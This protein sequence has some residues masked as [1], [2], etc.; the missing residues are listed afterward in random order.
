M[1]T[2]HVQRPNPAANGRKSRALQNEAHDYYRRRLLMLRKSGLQQARRGVQFQPPD[3]YNATD[4]DDD[5]DAD[6]DQALRKR[7]Q[8][9]DLDTQRLLDSS[10]HGIESES[11]ND[12]ATPLVDEDY[13][14]K[15]GMILGRCVE[16]WD[17][18]SQILDEGV[19]RNPEVDENFMHTAFENQLYKKFLLFIEVAPAMIKTLR[20]GNLNDAGS[21]L[22]ARLDRVIDLGRQQARRADANGVRSA[23]GQWPSINWEPAFPVVR[24]LL[25]FNHNTSGQL[26]CPVTLDWDDAK[27]REGLRRGTQDLT[28]ADLPTF[29]WPD[30]AFYT[31]DAYNGFLRS[32]LLVTTYKHIFISPSSA[33][34]TN[35]ST[36]GG[37]AA[38]H[39]ITFVTYESIAYVATVTHF[40]LSDEPSFGPG[41]SDADKR[42]RRGFPYRMFYREILDHKDL[43]SEDELISL[44]QWW[45]EKIF[46]RTIYTS[47]T[48]RKG[49]AGAIMRE[50]ARAKRIEREAAER[51]VVEPVS[52][53]TTSISEEI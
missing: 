53:S 15:K 2:I 8:Q 23:I 10:P 42:R 46:P 50:N 38:L 21:A 27:V 19:D 39:N 9:M 49:S 52:G 4:E 28:A 16:M 32:P 36:R 31:E 29:L 18:F 37:N 3:L 7:R 45:N 34:E 22:S 13:W 12:G 11:D 41:G 51:T 43:M 25:G 30:G 48:L 47:N 33:K 26:L 20:R 5:E 6:N 24:H 1:R 40:A 14:R 35:K 44:I 17:T